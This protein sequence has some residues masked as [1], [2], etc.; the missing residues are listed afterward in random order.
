MPR[1]RLTDRIAKA[2]SITERLD[3]L[4]S[5]LEPVDPRIALAIDQVSDKLEGRVAEN[6]PSKPVGSRFDKFYDDKD[7]INALNELIPDLKKKMD[8]GKPGSHH[9]IVRVQ[10]MTPRPL[11]IL[12]RTYPEKGADDYGAKD[13]KDYASEK[14]SHGY[15]PSSEMKSKFIF[16]M[17]YLNY[18]LEKD[19]V[20]GYWATQLLFAE[21]PKKDNTLKMNDLDEINF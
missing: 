8:E 9:D 3:S 12:I 14:D 16:T 4:A 19:V 18:K 21:V 20:N 6:K 5:E 11:A 13:R 7:F 2:I 15:Y 10:G 17:D 1:I